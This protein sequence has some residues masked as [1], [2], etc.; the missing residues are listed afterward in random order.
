MRTIITLLSFLFAISSTGQEIRLDSS[1]YENGQLEY[2]GAYFYRDGSGFPFG[3]WQ[4][5]YENGKKRLEFLGDSLQDKY[6][7][8]WT[9]D[10]SQILKDGQGLYYSIEP[11]PELTDSLVY[12]ITDSIKHGEYKRYR[13]WHDKPY[14]LVETGQYDHEKQTGRF[15]FED[16]ALKV[17]RVQYFIDNEENGTRQYFYLNGK[18]KDSV[19]YINGKPNGDYKLY[20]DEGVL[21][22][23][24]S[25]Q[26]GNLTGKYAEYYPSGQ[27]KVT[28]QYVQD[29]GY[30]K[31]HI[32]TVGGFKTKDRTENRLIPNK[33]LKHG[34]WTHYNVQGKIIR[35]E[36]YVRDKKV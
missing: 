27:P 5:W 19:R 36:K 26:G 25:Y 29:K 3:L 32:R 30:I 22:K 2:K 35:K 12:Q 23:E 11:Q 10:G 6:I 4:Y 33:A 9:S 15:V 21:L 14:Y 31:V 24:C 8:M 18:L 1:L 28:G 7:N 13:S 20:S 17:K 34:T 16:T